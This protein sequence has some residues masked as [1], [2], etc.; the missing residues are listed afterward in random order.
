MTRPTH[1]RCALHRNPDA[2]H[3]FHPD[4][5][6]CIHGCGNRDDGRVIVMTS[7]RVLIPGPTYTRE[8]LDAMT[9]HT[10]ED[11]PLDWNQA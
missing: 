11:T 1:T 9:R 4:S 7:G 10:P 8:Q 5:G 2:A 3:D 6:Y